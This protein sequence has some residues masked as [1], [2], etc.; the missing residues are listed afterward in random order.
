MKIYVCICVTALAQ[1]CA[2][3]ILKE[4]SYLFILS[5]YFYYYWVISLHKFTIHTNACICILHLP[6]QGIGIFENINTLMSSFNVILLYIWNTFSCLVKGYT[7]FV[8]NMRLKMWNNL[9]CINI[10]S[11]RTVHY[12]R[13]VFRI[14]KILVKSNNNNNNINDNNNIIIII[15]NNN[16][17]FLNNEWERKRKDSFPSRLGL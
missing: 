16:N 9:K 15:N 13:L 14:L 7:E 10:V 6:P 8:Y 3:E 4:N 2:C 12:L 17:F 11:N 5:I 1:V